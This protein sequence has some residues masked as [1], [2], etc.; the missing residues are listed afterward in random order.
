MLGEKV[1]NLGLESHLCTGSTRP[2][3]SSWERNSRNVVERGGA[4][5]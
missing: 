1:K 5:L 4:E 2:N 3:T